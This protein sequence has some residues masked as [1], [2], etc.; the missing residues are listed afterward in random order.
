MLL[1]PYRG[2]WNGAAGTTVAACHGVHGMV[3]P[4]PQPRRSPLFPLGRLVAT[5]GAL[6]A[7]ERSG[8]SA[9]ALVARHSRGDFGECGPDD[10]SANERAIRDGE[11]IF[12]VYVLRD[13]T[14]LWLITE[15][16]R[17]STCLLLPS[18]Y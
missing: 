16:D 12:S 14:K 7:L 9:Q 10:W 3:A 1:V 4:N 17:A 15:A 11:R 13:G 18:E 2:K 8:D 6:A 5:P